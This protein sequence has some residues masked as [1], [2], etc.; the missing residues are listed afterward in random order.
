MINTAHINKYKQRNGQVNKYTKKW[1]H[2]Q[3][4]NKANISDTKPVKEPTNNKRDSNRFEVKVAVT[5]LVKRIPGIADIAESI[6]LLAVE[7]TKFSL[8]LKN[9]EVFTCAFRN[10]RRYVKTINRVDMEL[11]RGC[12]F[13]PGELCLICDDAKEVFSALRQTPP[14]KTD[15]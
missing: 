6:F 15:G 1:P 3:V 12:A 9:R 4:N 11:G 7:K 5:D 2:K 14:N 13:G 10:V 8:F